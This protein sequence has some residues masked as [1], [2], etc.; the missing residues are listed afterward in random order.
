[1]AYSRMPTRSSKLAPAPRRSLAP[2]ERC[3]S[4]GS[5]T[6]WKTLSTDT[7]LKL[8]KMKPMVCRRSRV[9]WRSDMLAGGLARDGDRASRGRV[10]AADEIEQRGLAAA[11]GAGDGEELAFLDVQRYPAQ[12]GHHEGAEGVVLGDVLGRKRCSS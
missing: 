11:R 9:S 8:W 12:R 5:S 6:F 10:H 1:M 7:R 4:S 3:S 2:A